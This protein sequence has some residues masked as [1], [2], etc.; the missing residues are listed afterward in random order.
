VKLRISSHLT[1]YTQGRTSFE[2]SGL[3]L[4]EA[5]TDLDRQFPGI[6]FRFIDEQDQVREHFNVFVNRRVSNDLMQQLDSNSEID[7]IAALSGG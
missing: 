7:V 4:G 1:D 5:L 3:T 2:V 6:R